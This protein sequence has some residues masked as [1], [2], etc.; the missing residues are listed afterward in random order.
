MSTRSRHEATCLILTVLAGG[1]Q[2]GYGIVT[3]VRQI[4]GGRVRLRAGTLY[5]ALDRL[6]T[7]GL[8]GADREEVAASRVRRYYRLS[9]AS[10][11]W[12]PAGARQRAAGP[13][14]RIGD[15]DRDATVAALCDHFAQGRLTA[16]EL[17]ARL[18][19]VLAATTQGEVA[20]A[21]W[22]LP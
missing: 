9:A 4:S 20:R 17:G 14:L 11:G 13:Y 1:S 22:D 16:E 15:A 21:T 6:H 19:A 8:V 7:D 18:D 2:H 3:G 10:A 12:L 5:L